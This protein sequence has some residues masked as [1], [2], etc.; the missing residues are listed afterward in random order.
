MIETG[1]GPFK[2]AKD[3]SSAYDEI[4]RP[5]Y[6]EAAVD[7]YVDGHRA[8]RAFRLSDTYHQAMTRGVESRRARQRT[9]AITKEVLKNMPY[10]GMVASYWDIRADLRYWPT[11]AGEY[12]VYAGKLTPGPHTV[13]FRFYD[14]N[15][16]YLPRYD[17][18][19]HFICVP[20]DNELVMT[21]HSVENQ[22]NAYLLTFA[23][24][25]R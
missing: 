15:D 24:S 2:Y 7:V 22:D 6:R 11:L 14:I 23:P 25:A 3:R 5:P 17:I 13:H 10:V 18:T 8:G 20:S 1:A 16:K 19:R 21:V 4:G 9:K 12:H